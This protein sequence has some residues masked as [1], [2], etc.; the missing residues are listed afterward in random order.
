MGI[1]MR[2]VR[3]A[4]AG[5]AGT[6]AM[7]AVMLVGQRQGRLGKQP[8]EQ[9]T[10]AGLDA[11]DADADEP[12]EHALATAA[13]LGFGAGAGA[14]FELLGLRKAPLPAEVVGALYGLTVWAASYAGWI[15]A[16]GILPPPSRDRDDRVATM[17]TAHLVYGITLGGA[18]RLLTRA[19]R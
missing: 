9:I 11:A 6:V 10:E 2:S 5:A 7:S 1:L 8:P 13:H 16:A 15:P 18:S 17:L 12:T 19:G 14:A 4:A 3:G